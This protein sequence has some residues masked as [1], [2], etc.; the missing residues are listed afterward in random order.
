MIAD[1]TGFRG[2]VYYEAGFA[3]GLGKE[4]ILCCK[5]KYSIKIKY[6]AIDKEVIENG[7][8]F[9]VNHLNTIYWK[10]NDLEDF[11]ERLKNRIIGTVGRGSYSI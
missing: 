4:V 9:D 6:D 7:P 10:S 3:R 5:D 2:G 1:L 8:H 11:K